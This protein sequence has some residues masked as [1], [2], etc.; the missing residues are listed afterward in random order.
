MFKNANLHLFS[1]DR[2]GAAPSASL[3]HSA[4]PESSFSTAEQP[5]VA[6]LRQ[7]LFPATSVL[8]LYGA[9]L[10]LS[11]PFTHPYVVLAALAF[12]LSSRLL[13]AAAFQEL[14]PLAQ[15]ESFLLQV[16]LGWLKVLGVLLFIAFVAK[17]SAVY[18]RAVIIV[19]AAATPVLFCVLHILAYRSLCR[20]N[21]RGR[22]ARTHIIV[23]I[24][25]ASLELATTLE[26]D[27]SLGT[28]IGFFADT[29]VNSRS[30]LGGL[31][32]IAE[33]VRRNSIDVIHIAWPV[34]PQPRLRRLLGELRDTTASIYFV[35]DVP[36]DAQC[37]TRIVEMNGIPLLA[38]F[39]TPYNG[40]QG[41]TKRLIDISITVALLAIL[42]PVLLAIAVL[43]R[44]DS[45]G[46]VI[47]KQRR[48]GLNG[49]E[50]AVLKFR[51]MT[52]TEDGEQI[53]Q[54]RRNDVR[55]TRLGNFLRR[56]SLDELPQ[57]FC[58]LLGSMSLVGPRPHAVAHNEQYRRLI[59]GY[60]MRH[61]VRPGITGWAQV[62]GF[63]GETRTLEQMRKRV[64]YDLEY[65]RHWSPWV[66]FKILLRTARLVLRDRNAY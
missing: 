58:V 49:E 39:E 38:F 60:M 50:I 16:A 65:L 27:A 44:L 17:T 63:R 48:Y 45:P 25:A 53:V 46:P 4:V 66:D 26:R 22:I 11:Q 5:G 56:T 19:W 12:I 42:W 29:T 55:V 8:T 37:P 24:N 15:T 14:K 59:D 28:F 9:A 7:L 47:F 30:V 54:A 13:G 20:W 40:L 3:R 61:K 51:T 64:L 43:V 41:V 18:S 21:Q 32:D 35:L 57:L 10:A 36:R 34:D 62:N 31:D 1:A 2:A 33:Y 6:L 23:G 52:V